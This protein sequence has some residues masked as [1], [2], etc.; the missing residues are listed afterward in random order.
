MNNG[1]SFI[2]H[3]NYSQRPF[4]GKIDCADVREECRKHQIP[5][6]SMRYFVPFVCVIWFN[7]KGR[8][9]LSVQHD[10]PDTFA[11][12]KRVENTSFERNGNVRSHP[13]QRSDPRK[14]TYFSEHNPDIQGSDSHNVQVLIT[15]SDIIF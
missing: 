9:A 8:F 13:T 7:D 1:L 5:F 6:E 4:F 15:I 10:T 11:S 12:G 14:Q 2:Q 3:H